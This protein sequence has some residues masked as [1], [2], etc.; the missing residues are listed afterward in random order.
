MIIVN[1]QEITIMQI[2]PNYKIYPTRLS[3][4]RWFPRI[5]FLDQLK[6]V[7]SETKEGEGTRTGKFIHKICENF[8]REINFEEAD[9]NPESHFLDIVTYLS[10]NNWDYNINPKK[11]DTINEILRNFALNSAYSYRNMQDRHN[12]F[13]PLSLEE[14]IV[15]TKFPIAAKIDRINKSL[16]GVDYKT[17]AKFPMILTRNRADLN[18]SELIEYDY[19]HEHL[20]SQGVISSLLIE[21]KYGTLPKVFIFVYLRHLNLDGT[22]GIIPV[23]ITQD[24]INTILDWVKEMLEDITKDN[25]PSC[26]IRNPGACYAYNQPCKY[27]MFCESLPL[28]IFEL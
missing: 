4:K 2:D 24:K 16:T 15:S 7:E 19:S 25:F 27:K 3:Q 23:Y 13:I 14:E 17:D 21:E 8:F 22:R 10:N 1:G 12:K 20:L 26:R 9:K 5:W 6:T 28:C 18:P 11:V